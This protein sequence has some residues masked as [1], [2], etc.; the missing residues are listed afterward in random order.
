MCLDW[1][2]RIKVLVLT[3]AT[4]LCASA[5]HPQT[6]QDTASDVSGVHDFDFEFGDWQVH[7]RVTLAD[8]RSIEFDGTAS[9][10]PLI[11]GSGDIEEHTFYRTTGK[12]YGIGLRAFDK[13]TGTWAIWWVDSR[14]PHLP[15][16]P[17]NVGRFRDGVGTFFSES[18]VGGKTVGTRYIWSQIKHDSARW[19]QA[20]SVDGGKTWQ[21]NW[22]MEFRR[23]VP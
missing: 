8:G 20:L 7:H 5:M 4:M 21:T 6:T 22:I 19:E 12:T 2:S 3:I 1:I 14:Q 23:R 13:K 18:T 16:D 15:M 11:D 10:R 9:A 17:P